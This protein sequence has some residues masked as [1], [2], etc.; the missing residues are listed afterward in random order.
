MMIIAGSQLVFGN[1]ELDRELDR[2]SFDKNAQKSSKASFKAGVSSFVFER[3]FKQNGRK[4]L[5]VEYKNGKRDGIARFYYLNG[6]V[7]AK[8]NYKDDKKDGLSEFYVENGKILRKINY[9]NG[10]YNGEY[11]EYFENGNPLLRGIL[12]NGKSVG[13]FEFYSENG[14]LEFMGEYNSIK[15]KFMPK[16]QK[17]LQKTLKTN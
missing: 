12:Q 7:M 11:T 2:L 15:D 5:E 17:N 1:L 3:P 13:N 10:I 16:F 14:K 4:A 9:K 6:N 8:G